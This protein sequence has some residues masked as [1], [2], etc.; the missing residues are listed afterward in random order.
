MGD[1][2]TITG[3]V[4]AKRK[5][6]E[7]QNLVDVVCRFTNQRGDETVRATATIALPSDGKPVLYPEVPRALQEKAAMMMARHW[8][9]SAKKKKG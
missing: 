5:G 8:E 9:L 6:D 1:T 7:G 4:V 2:Q 3:E